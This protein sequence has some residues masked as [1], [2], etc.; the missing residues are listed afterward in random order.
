MTMLRR[1]SMRGAAD[2]VEVLVGSLEVL[3]GSLPQARLALVLQ[4]ASLHRRELLDNWDAAR[5]GE[6]LSR[7]R[8][9]E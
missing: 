5:R 1:T 4:W 6:P 3:R 8:G 2:E 7:I 9:L